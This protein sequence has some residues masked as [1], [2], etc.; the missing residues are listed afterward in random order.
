MIVAPVILAAGQGKRMVS[1]LPKALHLVGGQPMITYAV[2]LGR[3]CGDV[4][5]T[6]VVGLRAECVRK[7]IGNVASLVVQE[8]PLGTGHALLQADNS[9]RGKADLVLVWPADMPLLKEATLAGVVCKQREN[10]G[11]LS[12]VTVVAD[13]ARGFGRVIR[14]DR[15]HV[16]AVV[17]HA[18]LTEPQQIISELNAGVY[19]FD[20]DWLWD[21]LPAILPA[22]S[23]EY[24]LTDLIATASGQGHTIGA[25]I[26]KDETEA[27]GINTRVHLAQAEEALRHRVN[28]D[29]MERGVTI[30]D[31]NTAY[32]EPGV[33]IGRDTIILPNTHLAGNTTVG[34]ECVI[35]P[36]SVVRDTIIG[37]ACKIEC[38][39]LD[40]AVL[41]DSVHVGPYG[42]LRPGAILDDGVHVGNFGEVKQARLGPGV[43][44]GHFCYIGDASVGARTNIGAGT[45]TCNFGLDKKKHR[46][47]I[48]E[49]A[50]IG[51]DSLLVAPVTVGHRGHTGAGSVVTRDVPDDSLAVGV[52]ARVIKQEDPLQTDE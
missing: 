37:S 32:I 21:E 48:G 51:S 11:P 15:G 20:A 17:E 1:T 19:C 50:Y 46:T 34:E 9:L 7:A 35:G 41:G 40:E 30:T 49:D 14:D 31:P 3:R 47:Q 22:A 10:S 23:G 28:H 18:H 24:Y 45:I 5:P 8:E 27:I 38:S 39:V 25:I 2:E 16:C 36:N 26:M 44:M 29:W 43:K 6:F 42:H 12:I 33:T 13:D 52:P 4:D